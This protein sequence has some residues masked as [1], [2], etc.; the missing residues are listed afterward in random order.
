MKREAHIPF[1]ARFRKLL[2][3]PAPV[4]PEHLY[5]SARQLWLCARTGYPLVLR[6]ARHG[7]AVLAATEFGETSLT[8][9]IEG[10]DQSEG[11]ADR[12]FASAA[13]LGRSRLSASQFGE[14]SFTETVEGTDH[15]ETT[16]SE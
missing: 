1:V 14:T 9:T 16:A 6:H 3:A 2:R 12:G 7:V 5:D 8:R 15:A 4:G 11:H 10:T 13:S